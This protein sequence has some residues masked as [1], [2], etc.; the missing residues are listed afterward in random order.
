MA[1]ASIG[2]RAMTAGSVAG[3]GLLDGVGPRLCAD[4]LVVLVVPT[5]E[6]VPS[7][8]VTAPLVAGRAPWG[9]VTASIAVCESLL[10]GAPNRL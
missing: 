3:P 9:I 4:D 5:V 8:V 7:A 2:G 6:A 1:T 10:L